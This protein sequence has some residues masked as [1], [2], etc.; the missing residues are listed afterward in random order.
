M[1]GGVAL[2]CGSHRRYAGGRVVVTAP[3]DLRR[4]CGN[5]S[6]VAASRYF[7]LNTLDQQLTGI[8]HFH[9]KCAP[10][11]EH[12]EQNGNRPEIEGLVGSP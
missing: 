10:N 2:E 9:Q 12:S 11:A 5:A 3:S 4:A 8:F 7:P 6:I 1:Q